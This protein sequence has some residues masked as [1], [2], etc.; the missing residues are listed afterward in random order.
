MP[1]GKIESAQRDFSG[2]ELDVEMK[3]ADD[4]PVMRTGA[5]QM[6]NWRI[7]NSRAVKQRPGRT[8]LFVE[9]GRT[10]EIQLKPGQTFY[11]VFGNGYLRV[12]NA[13]GTRVFNT[14]TLAGGTGIPWTQFTA[15]A[16]TYAISG[17]NIYIFF[18]DAAPNNRPQVLSWDGVSQSSTWTLAAYLEAITAGGQ[19]RTFFAR[20]SPQNITLLPSAV[21]G[22]ITITF[23]AAVL[24]NGMIGA[25]LRYA[26][27]QLYITGVST[28]TIGSAQVVE[29][30][31]PGQI[32][33]LS[34]SVGF[35]AIGDVVRGSSSGAEGIVITTPNQQAAAFTFT[36]GVPMTVGQAVTAAP[37]GATGTIIAIDYTADTVTFS[38]TTST[39]FAN[40][41]VVSDGLGDS[42]TLTGVGGANLI[43]QLIPSSGTNVSVFIAE[44]VVGPSGS[45]VISSATTGS[46]QAIAVWDEEVMNTYR[47]YPSSV[48]FDQ[49]RLGLCNFPAT[50]SAIG[51]SAESSPTDMYIGA[52][53]QNAIFDVA[54]GNVQ[55]QYVVP[56]MESSEFV[57]C[58]GKIFYIPITPQIPLIPGNVN[59]NEIAAHGSMP[60]VQ[61]RRAEQSI[62]YMKAGGGA[63]GAVQAPGAYYRPYIIDSL[64]ELHAHLFTPSP[65]V[66]IAI[67]SA[68][69]QFEENYIYIRL[70]NGAVLVGR[71]Q[72]RQGLIEPGQDGKPRVGWSSWSGAGTA[73]WISALQDRVIFLTGYA[74]S[75]PPVI[76]VERLDATQYLDMAIPV[77]NLPAAFAPPG[78]KGPLFTFANGTVTLMDQGYRPMGVY[79]IDANGFIVPQNVGGENLLS[80]SLVAGQAW[81]AVLEPF[82]PDAQPGPDV[83]QRMFKRR[84]AR[85]AAYVSNSTGFLMARLFSGPVGPNE[86]PLGTIMNTYRVPAYNQDDDPTLPPPLREEAQRSR[87]LGKSFDPRVAIIK[88]SPGPLTI[89]ELGTKAS[90]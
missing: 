25:R 48:F 58:D 61:P 75:N 19:K 30:L 26:G 8:A 46:P 63:V 18:A 74:T 5:R 45:A 41:D 9:A 78:G 21:R 71:Y 77:N 44:T 52:Q 37:S 60:G 83:G 73:G 22:A 55:V 24:V 54:P 81:T 72:M 16:V 62:V 70:A 40:A 39:L 15:G 56:G 86:P 35:F 82:V 4:N 12:I 2:G 66:C 32:L 6:V 31:P 33:V 42:I 23:S 79:Q 17:L 67:P 84:V 38:L 68:S 51:W 50:P 43:V 20:I 64:S 90:I 34:S 36:S 47:G 28:P 87:P 85:F 29:P 13:I 27:R 14:T 53:P 89:H 10:E 76:I 59:F 57:F 7:L 88:D 65:A 80:A 69:T 49:S 11:L 1:I 3:R